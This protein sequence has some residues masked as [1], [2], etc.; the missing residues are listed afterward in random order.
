MTP[1]GGHG[2]A[3]RHRFDAAHLVVDIDNRDVRGDQPYPVDDVRLGGSLV[4]RGKDLGVTTLEGVVPVHDHTEEVGERHIWADVASV[5]AGITGVPCR[6]LLGHDRLDLL[7]C[8]LVL[9]QQGGQPE[10]E[11][12][13]QR[14]DRS[15]G[16]S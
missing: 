9:G 6:G 8:Q 10:R 15:H 3:A 1:S 7:A 11:H 2:D 5:P 4:E 16:F 12:Q 13:N 14:A